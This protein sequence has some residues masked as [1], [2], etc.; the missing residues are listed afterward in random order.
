MPAQRSPKSLTLPPDSFTRREA[1]IVAAA[2]RNVTIEDDQLTHFRL[3]I[4]DA[5]G[6]L[7]WRAWNFE[8]DA[9]QGLNAYLLSHGVKSR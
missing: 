5:G 8:A 6:L 4:R 9:G 2:Y 7:I 3:V 1:E